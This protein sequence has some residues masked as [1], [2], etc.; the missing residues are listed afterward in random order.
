MNP[1]PS[2]KSK[3]LQ[4]GECEKPEP[5]QKHAGEH[6]A[7]LRHQGPRRPRLRLID[8]SRHDRGPQ[9]THGPGLAGPAAALPRAGGRVCRGGPA[10]GITEEQ[11]QRKEAVRHCLAEIKRC[12]PY[13]IGLLG[14]RCG[15]VPGPEAYPPALLEEER[16][17]ER[18]IFF[19]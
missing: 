15:W 17:L 2:A 6:T 4:P 11:A 8:V 19:S 12:R 5:I 16:W 13:F 7:A 3:Y 1:P 9:R 14:E 18:D 10:L